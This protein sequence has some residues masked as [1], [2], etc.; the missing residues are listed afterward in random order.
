MWYFKFRRALGGE[1][2]TK[3]PVL[4]DVY[5]SGHGRVSRRRDRGFLRLCKNGV[6]SFLRLFGKAKGG[7]REPRACGGSKRRCVRL[8]CVSSVRVVRLPVGGAPGR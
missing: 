2:T 8:G 3:F 7:G 5:C 4:F 6:T 1:G